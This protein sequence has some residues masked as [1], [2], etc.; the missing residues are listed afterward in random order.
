MFNITNDDIKNMVAEAIERLIAENSDCL[1]NEGFSDVLYHNTTLKS[2]LKISQT[3]GFK[4]RAAL[5]NSEKPMD[6]S[7]FTIEKL[8]NNLVMPSGS[9]YMSFSRERNSKLGYAGYK[10]G[11]LNHLRDPKKPGR[12]DIKNGLLVRFEFDGRALQQYIG[13]KRINARGK[14]IDY[15][16]D[17]STMIFEPIDEKTQKRAIKEKKI[18]SKNIN[19]VKLLFFHRSENEKLQLY[20]AGPNGSYIKAK[21][22]DENNKLFIRTQ[23][24]AS[25]LPKSNFRADLTPAEKLQTRQSEDRLVANQEFFLFY[26]L[27][28]DVDYGFL[29][30]IDILFPKAMQNDN[31]QVL[32]SVCEAINNMS[33]SI[34]RIRK[35][36]SDLVRIFET[37]EAYDNPR[38]LPGTYTT[39]LQYDSSKIKL[40]KD[41]FEP[42]VLTKM[43]T[44]SV[45]IFLIDK[46]V[47]EHLNEEDMERVLA[48]KILDAYNLN[49]SNEEYEKFSIVFKN[50]W[51]ER[52]NKFKGMKEQE[53]YMYMNSL[54]SSLILGDFTGV[55]LNRVKNMLCD[56]LKRV[57]TDFSIKI[58][59]EKLLG[60][61]R[62]S[63][64]VFKLLH[65]QD[66]KR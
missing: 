14:A 27:E 56:L 30:H 9:Y 33:Y 40:E 32:A 23:K 18:K 5:G 39:D 46:L 38:V 44:L 13:S 66:L 54:T 3:G 10:N 25:I 59:S 65:Q 64:Y 58:G 24:R 26:D 31:P 16:R 35:N 29:K 41:I 48:N 50:A 22:G 42:I 52:M 47:N 34:A 51:N 12:I 11:D 60:G 57:C 63:K 6:K 62:I 55:Y 53:L 49:L 4:L 20:V 7:N 43:G 61:A 37:K 1:I 45:S 28:N 36:N 21:K 19:G 8:T 2:L 17:P 15:Y